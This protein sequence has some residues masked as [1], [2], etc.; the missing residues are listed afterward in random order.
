MKIKSIAFHIKIKSFLLQTILFI[1]HVA[2]RYFFCLR[3]S[4]LW[5]GTVLAFSNGEGRY[6]QAPNTN[7]PILDVGEPTPHALSVGLCYR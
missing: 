1:Q 4:A 5:Y 6:M 7:D 2:F 3:K